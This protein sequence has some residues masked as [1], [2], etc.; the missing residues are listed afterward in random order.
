MSKIKEMVDTYQCP[1]CVGGSS[2]E[3]GCYIERTSSYEGC[4]A[5]VSGT[6]SLSTG[7]FFLGMP[8]GFTRIGQE[9]NM[10]L[11]LF[12]SCE[13]QEK[14]W[15]YSRYNVPVWKFL[16]SNG[17]TLVR[18]LKPRLNAPFIHIIRGNCL[19]KIDCLE[20]TDADISEMD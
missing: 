12:S 19:D 17:N 3:D 7:K 20:I 10:K 6:T 18:G 14:M 4:S 13:N 16:D 1:G 11:A 5:H 9:K 2:T 8:T 15:E